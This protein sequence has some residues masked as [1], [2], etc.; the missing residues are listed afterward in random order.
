MVT[1]ADCF[2]TELRLP[3]KLNS[4]SVSSPAGTNSPQS[5][6]LDISSGHAFDNNC[7]CHQSSTGLINDLVG[8]LTEC[9]CG[10][11]RLMTQ[12]AFIRV[13]LNIGEKLTQLPTKE[14]RSMH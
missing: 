1:S 5:Q 4:C 2:S 8:R 12:L 9:H 6:A 14:L 13:L 3:T 11:D 10:A 7:V